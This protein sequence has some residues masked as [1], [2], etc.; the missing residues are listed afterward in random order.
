MLDL[1][2]IIF[3]VIYLIICHLFSSHNYVIIIWNKLIAFRTKKLMMHCNFY[4]GQLPKLIY[5]GLNILRHKYERIL[6]T[7]KLLQEFQ[8]FKKKNTEK[9]TTTKIFRCLKSNKHNKNTT[10]KMSPVKFLKSYT[11]TCKLKVN[12][13]K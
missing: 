13:I 8:N 2:K 11:I 10:K 3:E 9:K 7:Y 12:Q 1:T 6:Q 4:V 5:W